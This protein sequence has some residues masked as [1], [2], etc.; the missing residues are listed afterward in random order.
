MQN[1]DFWALAKTLLPSFS[2]FQRYWE[3]GLLNIGKETSNE[4]EWTNTKSF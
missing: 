3:L 4:Q 2:R 1:W